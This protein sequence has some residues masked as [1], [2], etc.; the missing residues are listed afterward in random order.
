MKKLLNRI[1]KLINDGQEIL[2]EER[3]D[4]AL[5]D[6]ENQ[7]F[8]MK[9]SAW[10]LSC[11]NY[12]T[13]T[14]MTLFFEEFKS[15]LSGSYYPAMKIAHLISILKSAK[16]EIENGFVFQIKYL[17]HA[18]FYDSILDQAK[19]LYE[20]GH[21]TPATVLARIIIEGWLK[22]KAEQNNIQFKE[23]EKA[24]VINDRLKDKAYPLPLWRDIQTH[25][26]VGNAAAHG[27]KGKFT[28]VQVE[29]MFR[30]IE[31]N[32]FK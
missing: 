5:S 16:D 32:C 1:E 17:L 30:F 15:V 24:A 22:D 18:D 27:E 4:I 13:K 2:R 20:S 28:N 19:G 31:N 3:A 14:E 12:F 10:I 9:K 26:D 11:I 7:D 25:L 8:Q 21:I 6:V 29:N 23:K